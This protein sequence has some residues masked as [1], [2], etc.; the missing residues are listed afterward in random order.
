MWH[1]WIKF[2]ANLKEKQS[3]HTNTNQFRKNRGIFKLLRKSEFEIHRFNE[4]YQGEVKNIRN[5]KSYHRRN[6]QT[7]N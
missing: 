4:L 3:K 2:N 7:C 5:D 1:C 6:K